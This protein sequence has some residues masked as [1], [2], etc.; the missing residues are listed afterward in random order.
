MNFSH[1]VGMIK[2]S[3]IFFLTFL[4]LPTFSQ[5]STIEAPKENPL[6]GV[7]IDFTPHLM[8][9]NDVKYGLFET[10]SKSA[11]PIEATFAT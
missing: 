8:R 10:T 9:K 2:A 7:S 11:N 4:S 1:A 6:G 3:L 5:E